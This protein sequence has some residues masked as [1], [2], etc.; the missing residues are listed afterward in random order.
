[1]G[2]I[3]KADCRCGF[4][5]EMF[6]GG[7][8]MNFTKYC[9]YPMYC[10]QC[11]ILFESNLFQ[12]QISCPNCN[13]AN[14]VVPYD[15]ERVCRRK[16]KEVFRWATEHEI[17]RNLTLTDGEYLCPKCGRFTLSFTMSGYWD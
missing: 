3:I 16:G 8:M 17:G 7:G 6:L 11:R 9:A 15:H 10:G 5:K 12:K 1:M 2:T 13:R 4:E 14:D